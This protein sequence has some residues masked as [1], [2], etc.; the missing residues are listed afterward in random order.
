MS[1]CRTIASV[2]LAAIGTAAQAQ[3]VRGTIT[4][5]GMQ[6]DGAIVLLVDSAGRFVARGASRESGA[7]A[8][9]ADRSGR[10]T[11]RVLR[12][13]YAPTIVGPLQ[14]ATGA[15]TTRNVS[16]TGAPVRI[17]ELRITDR[18]P[19]QVRPDSDAVA[20]RLW[21]EART[22]LLA[23]ALTQREQLTMRTSVTQRLLD[24]AGKRVLSE[25]TTTR[26]IPTVRPFVSLPPDSL[27]AVGYV[28]HNAQGETEY[29]APDADVLLSESF[30]SSHCLRPERPAADTGIAS[31]WIG[32]AFL[33][34][35]DPR[36]VAEVEGVLWLDRATAELRRLDYH[37]VNLPSAARLAERVH[38]GGQV[39]FMRLPNGGWIV[40]RWAIRYP[41]LR[42]APRAPSAIVP[43]MRRE[44]PAPE[45]ELAGV[46]VTAGEVSDVHRGG[47]T[48]WERGRVGYRV[49]VLGAERGEPVAGAT[50]T[51]DDS[52]DTA[53]T[54]ADGVAR[55]ARV[56]PGAHRLSLRTP[57]MS[58]LG[59]PAADVAVSVPDEQTSP[60]PIT[61]P[62]DRIVL[63]HACGPRSAARHESLLHGSLRTSALPVPDT[64]VEAAWQAQF[65]RLGGG[66]PVLVPR[67]VVATTNARG[68]FTMC[69]LPRGVAIALRPLR[70]R[71]TDRATTV[72]IPS[73]AVGVEQL[74]TVEP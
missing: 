3:S 47:A 12:I 17:A 60:W 13:G 8:L 4:R 28:L 24:Q 31:R 63:A 56:L 72:M 44:T 15:V 73:F 46:R 40:P 62:T 25:S 9:T 22:A 70:D 39:E 64:R 51:M 61:A 66:E 5:D 10:Y 11:L 7:Y 35:G 20:F 69:G 27:V 67:R 58:L 23:T 41:V 50:A 29:W 38:A 18:A 65:A 36:G 16:L 48:L 42:A 6:I 74:V 30:A 21:E 45:L 54:G 68:E 32:I 19:C 59:A 55:F 37:Y 1:A 57:I 34:S 52:R 33:P 53:T 43:G 14:L 49:R 71:T 26:V 2:L